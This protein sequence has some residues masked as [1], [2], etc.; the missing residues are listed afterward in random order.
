MH[1]ITLSSYIKDSSKYYLDIFDTTVYGFKFIKFYKNNRNVIS[2]NRYYSCIPN[3]HGVYIVLE[4]N[5][6]NFEI[7]LLTCDGDLKH[8]FSGRF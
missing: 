6:K 7:F 2:I 5:N 3:F 4:E 8:Y 1:S